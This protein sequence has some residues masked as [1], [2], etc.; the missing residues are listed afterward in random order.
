MRK[1]FI[2]SAFLLLTAC[3]AAPSRFGNYTL[4]STPAATQGAMAADAVK[5]LVTMFPP[6]H[7]R[8]NMAQAVDE[9]QFGVDLVATLRSRGYAVAEYVAPVHG[10]PAVAPGPG[11]SLA[12][13]LTEQASSN[14]YYLT[15]FV[16][17]QVV[18]RVYVAQNGL[19]VPIGAWTHKE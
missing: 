9:D 7:N 6:A 19:A 10:V 13:T 3:A 2:A 5:Q 8:F 15:L 11:A 4:P 16:G 14:M 1:V 12:Y 18:S 17:P